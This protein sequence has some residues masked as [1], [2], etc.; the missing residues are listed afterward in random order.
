LSKT[1]EDPTPSERPAL[2]IAAVERETGLSKDLLRVWE[3]RYGFPLPDRD[4]LGERVYPADQV[5]RLRWIRRLIDSGC[6]PGQ[7]VGLGAEQLQ[8]RVQGLAQD[9]FL[10]PSRGS[11]AHAQLDELLAPLLAHD[12]PRLHELLQ[13]E[14]LKQGL[15]AYVRN[16]LAPLVQRVGQLWAEGR[17]QVYEE[18]LFTEIVQQQLRRSIA[19]LPQPSPEDGPRVLLSTL[20]G[21]EHG[22]GLLMVHAL[23]AL[24]GCHCI[25]LG[26][27]TP[28]GDLLE[29]QR[30]QAADVLALSFSAYSSPALIDDG[31]SALLQGLP[32]AIELWAGGSAAGLRRAASRWPQLQLLSELQSLEGAVQRWRLARA[33]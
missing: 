4:G 2:G 20:P 10:A 21:E 23:L 26:L 13:T 30:R 1:N 19:M 6:R 17:L 18:H 12:L 9:A 5:Q 29:A 15:S 25:S 24:Q 16:V 31:L 11:P 33:S 14:L 22:L 28:V 32:E 27:Q 8:Q 7:V 3:R